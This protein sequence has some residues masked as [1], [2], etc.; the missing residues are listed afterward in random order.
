MSLAEYTAAQE[1]AKGLEQVIAVVIPQLQ[2][3]TQA[4]AAARP[5]PGKWSKKEIIGHLI[6]S[7][8]NNHQ[9]FVRAQQGPIEMPGY[10]QNFWVEAQ[11]YQDAD[12]ETLVL[13][14]ATI[15]G[16]LARVMQLIPAEA[17]QQTCRIGNHEPVTLEFLVTD[18]L[19]HFKHHLRQLQVSF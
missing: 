13:V 8:L 7:A 19:D 15:N 16:N 10:D 12:W 9:R 11:G 17:L 1:T 4:E 18:Y 6:D 5:A 3:F 2:Q 14:W